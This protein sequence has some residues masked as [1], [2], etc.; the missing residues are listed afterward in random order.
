MADYRYVLKNG[1]ITVRGTSKVL[2]GSDYLK[3]SISICEPKQVSVLEKG[4]RGIT[5][6]TQ[7]LPAG[8]W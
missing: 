3:R 5:V 7:H 8:F 4:G 6:S 1:E 2:L